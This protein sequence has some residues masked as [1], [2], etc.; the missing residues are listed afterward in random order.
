DHVPAVLRVQEQAVVV[1]KAKG[2]ESAQI[3]G[4]SQNRLHVKRYGLP[5]VR[6][7]ESGLG[8]QRQDPH[9]VEESDVLLRLDIHALKVMQIQSLVAIPGVLER[10][11]SAAG[12]SFRLVEVVNLHVGPIAQE[13]GLNVDARGGGWS[14]NELAR[15]VLAR[16]AWPN[17]HRE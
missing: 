5:A 8:A 11:E 12:R 17:I 13:I 7:G 3:V 6:V 9:L 14:K 1:V 10:I 4:T 15:R 2:Q 16:L